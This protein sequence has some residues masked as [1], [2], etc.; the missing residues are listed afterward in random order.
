[1]RRESGDHPG[2]QAGAKRA[3]SQKKEEP[4]EAES[5]SPLRDGIAQIIGSLQ[6][7]AKGG[8]QQSRE[9]TH[10]DRE[11]SQEQ[12]ITAALRRVDPNS[13]FAFH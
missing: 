10:N 5:V 1:L 7:N 6:T 4:N 11:D 2:G 13:R 3:T 12:G 9:G 8:A